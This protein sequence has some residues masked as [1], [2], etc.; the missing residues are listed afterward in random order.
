MAYKGIVIGRLRFGV[1]HKSRGGA[2]RTEVGLKL[3]DQVMQ[4][5]DH[6]VGV[7]LCPWANNQRTD[8]DLPPK[9]SAAVDCNEKSPR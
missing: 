9:T 6:R 8:L 5:A 3:D 7:A 4:N 2:H 1:N